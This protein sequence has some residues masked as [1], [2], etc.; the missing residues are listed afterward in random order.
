MFKANSRRPAVGETHLQTAKSNGFTAVQR[1]AL[2]RLE[3]GVALR[4][5]LRFQQAFRG[6]EPLP[7]LQVSMRWTWP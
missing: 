1:D 3:I 7:T 4:L 5:V 6:V 2:S